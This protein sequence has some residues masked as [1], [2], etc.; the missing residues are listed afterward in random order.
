MEVRPACDAEGWRAAAQL[1]FAYQRETAVELGLRPPERP[2]DV[3]GPVRHEVADPAAAFA[4][5]LI[6]YE[7]RHPLGGLAVVA[8]DAGSVMLKRAYVRPDRRRQGVASA[9]AAAANGEAAQR[10]VSRLV[11]DI[12]GSRQDGIA[13]WRRLGF[14][15][16]QPWGDT[17]MRC[18]ER[19]L[20]SPE[21]S[22]WLGLRLDLVALRGHDDRWPKVVEHHAEVLRR[23]VPDLVVRVE[24]VGSTAVPGLAAKPVVDM[25]VLLAPDADEE[26]LVV[27]L[28]DGGY[29]FRGDKGDGGGLLFVA[30][31]RPRHR[32]AHIHVLR[33]ADPQ[34]D[35]YL[36]I[37][38]V[39][40]RDEGV[41]RAYAALKR[42]LADRFPDNRMAYTAAKA[43]FLRGLLQQD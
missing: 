24:H 11:V 10:G 23:V 6:A 21:P 4:T 40:R 31:D 33:H 34:W 41:R 37:R 17:S 43:S 9:L 15:E 35:E 27:S 8:H 38:D 18:F 16:C 1:L 5:Y 28:E 25:A 3:W 20:T 36:L 22:A 32:V 19:P 30:E 13:A 2:Q 12:L 26:T 39:L 14:V 29:V 42:E 7:G